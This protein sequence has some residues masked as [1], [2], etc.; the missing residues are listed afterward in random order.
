MN[1]SPEDQL[2]ELVGEDV[3]ASTAVSTWQQ[4]INKMMEPMNEMWNRTEQQQYPN[5]KPAPS[6][7]HPQDKA[8]TTPEKLKAARDPNRK[9]K[10]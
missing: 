7:I 1:L 4:M 3:K 8:Y 5:G 6:A 2:L 9:I 10:T